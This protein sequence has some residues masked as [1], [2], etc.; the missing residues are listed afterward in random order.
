M[1]DMPSESSLSMPSLKTG[2][3]DEV[4]SNVSLKNLTGKSKREEINKKK[5]GNEMD[6]FQDTDL[7]NSDI[8][9]KDSGK[10]N[11]LIFTA[12]DIKNEAPISDPAGQLADGNAPLQLNTT[13]LDPTEPT[14]INNIDKIP[15][16]SP[17]SN[18][19][20]FTPNSQDE[21]LVTS[22]SKDTE[23]YGQSTNHIESNSGPLQADLECIDNS[24]E[25]EAPVLENGIIEKGPTL[26]YEYKPGKPIKTHIKTTHR[27]KLFCSLK[28]LQHTLIRT[29]DKLNF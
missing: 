15:S 9:I 8:P 6:A 1:I 23:Y 29:F 17:D 27:C 10:I 18:D 19:K 21:V 7:T 22:I 26:K 11:D 3:T 20:E 13:D 4:P 25:I 28:R 24:I 5:I 14:I 12:T 16:A 2:S